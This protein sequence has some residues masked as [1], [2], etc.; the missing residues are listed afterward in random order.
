MSGQTEFPIAK[1]TGT[2]ADTL[3]AVGLAS[4]LVTL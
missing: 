2:Y 3:K 1:E 4:I